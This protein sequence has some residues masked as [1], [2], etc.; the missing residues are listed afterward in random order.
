MTL[1]ALAG[2][3]SLLDESSV[4]ITIV[5]NSSEDRISPIIE[6]RLASWKTKLINGHG[7]IGFGRG[8][9]LALA[10]VGKFHLFLNPDVKTNRLSLQNAIGF[11]QANPD[12]GLLSPRA[13]WP[14]G[15]RQYLCKR[16][17]AVF[18]LVLRGFAPKSI[19]KTFDSRLS[20]YEMRLE[21]QNEVFWNPPIVSGCFMLFKG[22]VL[23]K[24]GG[25]D[26][27]FFLYFE[28]FDLSIRSGHITRIAY[29]PHV[30][31]IHMGGHAAKKGWWH[32][33]Q[34]FWSSLKFYK[35]HGFRLI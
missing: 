15:K 32:I 28:D 25:F 14:D 7:N 23:K 17:P 10:D 9:N 30:K 18:D 5:D 33:W 8:H 22:S 4:A 16:F 34:F 31:I 35:M 6:T 2:A 24:T 11:M 12:C 13:Y 21:T 20:R 27:Q 3:L 26:P 1:S 19:Q 29:N